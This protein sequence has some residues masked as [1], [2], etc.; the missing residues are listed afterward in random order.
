VLTFE[1]GNAEDFASK[2]I[3]ASR[4]KDELAQ[5]ALRGRKFADSCLSKERVY[6]PLVNWVKCPGFAPDRG[7]RVGFK[8]D[9]DEHISGLERT[10]SEMNA[11]Y[12]CIIHDLEGKRSHKKSKYDFL[13]KLLKKNRD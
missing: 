7:K 11:Y 9:R 5:I 8:N 3:W 12:L 6:I 10:L 1:S 4:N 2:L 13:S